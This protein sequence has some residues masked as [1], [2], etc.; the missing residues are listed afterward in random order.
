MSTA[1][2]HDDKIAGEEWLERSLLREL[3][4]NA[5][6]NKH[7]NKPVPLSIATDRDK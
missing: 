2:T 6:V 1:G 3:Y 7:I 4:V 5:D